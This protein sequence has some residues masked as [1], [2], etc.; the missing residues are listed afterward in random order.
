MTSKI[1]VYGGRIGEVHHSKYFPDFGGHEAQMILI[2]LYTVMA[3]GFGPYKTDRSSFMCKYV[4]LV[5]D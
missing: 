1:D 4:T 3:N 5:V 2:V